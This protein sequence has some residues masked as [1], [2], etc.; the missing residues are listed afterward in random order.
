MEKRSSCRCS[1]G[2]RHIIDEIMLQVHGMLND[3]RIVVG[4]GSEIEISHHY[5][6]DRFREFGAVI[7]DVINR[8]LQTYCSATTTKASLSFAQAK[9]RAFQILYGDLEVEKNGSPRA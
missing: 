8:V 3:A 5:R 1:Q 6:L 4:E 9:G 7:I 2:A